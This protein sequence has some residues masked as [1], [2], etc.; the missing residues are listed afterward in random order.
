MASI[1]LRGTVAEIKPCEVYVDGDAMPGHEITLNQPDFEAYN[2]SQ[3]M[4][5][6]PP[7]V[8]I[9]AHRLKV[10]P[11][12]GD[13]VRIFCRTSARRGSGENASKTYVNMDGRLL[14][15]LKG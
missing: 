15:V 10:V 7:K 14:E 9:G 1:E 5:Y 3:G 6:F 13:L 8:R 11:N 2:T 4:K 12:Y